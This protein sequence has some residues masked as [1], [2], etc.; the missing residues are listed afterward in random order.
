[1]ENV[2]I[3]G[4]IL[5]FSSLTFTLSTVLIWFYAERKIAAFFQDRY[6]PLHVGKAGLLQPVA[7]LLKLI[8]KE[9]I[10]HSG[11]RKK[12]FIMAPLLVFTAVFSGFA[13]VPLFPFGTGFSQ[14]PGGIMILMGL[15]SIESVAILMA[16]YASKSQFPLLGAGRVIAQMVSYEVPLAI[17]LICFFWIADS[18]SLHGIE[19][20]QLSGPGPSAALGWPLQ[21]LGL[22]EKGGI[23]CWNIL[24]CPVLILLL[25]GFFLSILAESNRAPFDIPEGDSEIIGGYHTEYSGFLWSV[26][27]LAEYALMLILSLVLVYLFLGGKASPLPGFGILPS[28]SEPHF[29][30][31]VMK[32]WFLGLIMIWIR[33]TLPRLRADQLMGLCWKVLT[34]I[35]LL[36]L[37]IVLIFG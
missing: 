13:L 25:P 26:F 8:Q 3:Q 15:I 37:G 32:T 2:L 27:F 1:M 10:V 18:S 31:M 17:S 6:G 12:M 35:S 36:V 11:A 33:W 29:L 21:S 9:T 4:L 16:A 30:W 5:L 14:I 19:A 20:R 7:D 24:R 22:A 28:L 23:F 34:P